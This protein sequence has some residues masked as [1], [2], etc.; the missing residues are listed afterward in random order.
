MTAAFVGLKSEWKI[1]LCNSCYTH[2]VVDKLG[3][4]V[5]VSKGLL[6]PLNTSPMSSYHARGRFHQH[7][8]SSFCKRVDPKSENGDQ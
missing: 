4:V 7:F 2:L 3:L 5:Q 1:L 8:A 6:G